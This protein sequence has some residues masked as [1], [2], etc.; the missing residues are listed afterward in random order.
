MVGNEYEHTVDTVV[1]LVQLLP[2]EQL[3]R[4]VDV[5]HVEIRSRFRDDLSG[6]LFIEY[7]F[8]PIDDSLPYIQAGVRAFRFC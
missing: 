4:V 7:I 8:R 1:D 3:A 6:S 5:D 2:Q